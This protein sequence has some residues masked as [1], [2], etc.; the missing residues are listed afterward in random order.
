M[1]LYG[2]LNPIYHDIDQSGYSDYS[3][4]SKTITMDEAMIKETRP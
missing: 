4:Y 3:I 2:T 1:I